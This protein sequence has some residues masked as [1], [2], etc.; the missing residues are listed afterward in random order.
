MAKKKKKRGKAV[1]TGGL[2]GILLLFLFNGNISTDLFGDGEQIDTEPSQVEEIVDQTDEE[3][4][5]KIVDN[6]IFFNEKPVL[7]ENIISEIGDFTQVILR[8]T[9]AKQIT[10]D[11]VKSLLNEHNIIIVEE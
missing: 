4:I 8:A 3:V 1:A 9:D 11:E 6:T 2:A 7:L 5:I 10:Y